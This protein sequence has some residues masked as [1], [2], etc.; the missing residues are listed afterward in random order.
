[1]EIFHLP[2]QAKSCIQFHSIP[3]IFHSIPYHTK[4]LPFH[5]PYFSIPGVKLTPYASGREPMAREPDVA[6]FVAASGSLNI[7]LMRLLRMKLFLSFSIYLTTKPQATPCSTTS[8]I[9]SGKHVIKRKFRHL[10][11]FKIV[12]F[13]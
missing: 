10:P 13:A 6:L 7:F 8:R 11:L 4:D 5:L 9:S 2:Q 12:G 1:M 3:E